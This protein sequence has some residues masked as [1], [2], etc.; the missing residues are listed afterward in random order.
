M[1]SNKPTY[2]PSQHPTKWSAFPSAYYT[3]DIAA[4]S[5]TEFS[6]FSPA[7]CKSFGATDGCAYM[8]AQLPAVYSAVVSTVVPADNAAN[9]SAEHA[10]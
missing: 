5:P 10:T 6:A 9:F 2:E 1:S 7:E 3:A 4:V 8:P